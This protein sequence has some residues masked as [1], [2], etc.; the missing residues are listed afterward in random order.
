MRLTI[1]FFV[2]L[3]FSHMSHGQMRIQT[4]PHQLIISDTLKISVRNQVKVQG[5]YNISWQVFE[6]NKWRVMRTDIFNNFPMANVFQK[7]GSTA[8]S[9]DYFVIDNIFTGTFK[10]Y[11][12]LPGRLVLTYSYS[13]DLKPQRVVYSKN[14]IV[15]AK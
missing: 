5:F 11:K 2:C 1:I 3:S 12:Q 14:F 13:S 7:I 4:F 9:I 6:R 15:K 8:D 10:K